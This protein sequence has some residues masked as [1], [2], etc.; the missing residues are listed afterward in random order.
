MGTRW[1]AVHERHV[2]LATLQAIGAVRTWIRNLVK[3]RGSGLPSG[4][5]A[6]DSQ[7][8]TWA[9]AESITERDVE[10]TAL[11]SMCLLAGGGEYLGRFSHAPIG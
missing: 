6:P 3:P 10:R 2:N 8:S 5:G 11:P 1:P 4:I 9:G 7:T